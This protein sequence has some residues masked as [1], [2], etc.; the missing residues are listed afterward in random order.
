MGDLSEE[1]SK[2]REVRNYPRNTDVI[3][4]YVFRNEKQYV[5]GGESVTD[6]RTVSI[7]MRHSFIEAPEDDFRPRFDDP[8]VG[9]FVKRATDLS[10]T[11]MMP[12]CKGST[13]GCL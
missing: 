2:I 13:T 5:D 1:R 4:E 3:V 12:V 10:S 11:A 6:P 7:R 8:R 9:Y